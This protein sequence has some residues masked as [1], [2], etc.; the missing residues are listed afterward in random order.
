MLPRV[1]DGYARVIIYGRQA[2]EALRKVDDEMRRAMLV[3]A[4]EEQKKLDFR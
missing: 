3:D 2:R 1:E 4:G